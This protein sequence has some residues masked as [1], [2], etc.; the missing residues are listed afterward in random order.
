[1][2]LGALLV[3]ISP[4]LPQ[5]D[6]GGTSLN[7]GGLLMD[8]AASISPAGTAVNVSR[9]LAGISASTSPLGFA[10]Y[11]LWLFAPMGMGLVLLLGVWRP[12]TGGGSAVRMLT[13]V[14]LLLYSFALA[15][16]GSLLLTE[17]AGGAQGAAVSFPLSLLLFL[18]PLLLGG[19]ALARAV[20]GNF[21]ASSGG[22]VRLSLGLLLA[23][24]GAL[25]LDSG[26][27]PFGLG[28]APTRILPG[29]WL[30]PVGGM[31][32]AAGELLAR[33]PAR[34]AAAPQ[35]GSP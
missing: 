31:L 14:L 7:A 23:L 35:P 29:A 15:T 16:S 21:P 20:G 18:L 12:S 11:A 4:L 2:R 6:R 10:I 25:L 17:S 9:S 3:L 1:M 24:N 34:P 22:Y 33:L 13:L 30:L 5:C 19:L 32:V 8:A 28:F 26:W 27:A